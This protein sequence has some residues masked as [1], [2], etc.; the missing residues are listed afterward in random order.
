MLS[1]SKISW[2]RNLVLINFIFLYCKIKVIRTMNEAAYT[3]ETPVN[4][5]KIT[6][7]MAT[8]FHISSSF[9]LQNMHRFHHTAV[10]I[11][12][13]N[14]RCTNLWINTKNIFLF[15]LSIKLKKFTSKISSNICLYTNK[16]ISYSKVDN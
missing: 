16:E 11:I 5:Y 10:K 9:W 14:F 6:W 8:F 7:H 13:H 4:F 12:C 15:S 3:S 2:K 1:G